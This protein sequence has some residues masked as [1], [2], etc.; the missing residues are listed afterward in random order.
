MR[1]LFIGTF[2]D[3]IK[4]WGKQGHSII[5]IVELCLAKDI[6]QLLSISQLVG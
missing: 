1:A 2:P 4:Q 6:G 5:S 3:K